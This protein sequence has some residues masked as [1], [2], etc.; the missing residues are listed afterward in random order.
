MMLRTLACTGLLLLA[1][2]SPVVAQ[3][4]MPANLALKVVNGNVYADAQG[5][6]YTV[7]PDNNNVMCDP[8]GCMVKVCNAQG[9][10]SWNY[11]T[12]ENCTP[13]HPGGDNVADRKK[14]AS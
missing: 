13:V 8:H 4:D 5:H 11:C 3:S 6:R 14:P 2:A 10:C 7:Q 12:Q 9:T 1:A